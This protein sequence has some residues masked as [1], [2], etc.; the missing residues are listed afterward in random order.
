M[1]N[2]R[3]FEKHIGNRLKVELAS[4]AAAQMFST[5]EVTRGKLVD[6]IFRVISAIEPDLSDHGPCW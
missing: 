5:Y 2:T 4:D 1:W 3:H 6:N